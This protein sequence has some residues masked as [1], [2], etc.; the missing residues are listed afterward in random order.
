MPHVLLNG[1]LADVN[2]EFQEFSANPLST[3][4]S[5]FLLPS[6][7]IKAMVSAATFGVCEEALDLRF[8][9][10]RKSSRCQRSSVSG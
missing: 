1:S 9:S 2:A 10:R 6:P 4:E 7:L 3:P 5:I 8:Q